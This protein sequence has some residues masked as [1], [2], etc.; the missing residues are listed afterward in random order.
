MKKNIRRIS[1]KNKPKDIYQLAYE[2][3]GEATPL[4][5]A[6]CGELCHGICCQGDEDTGM[7]LYPFEEQCYPKKNH[8]YRIIESEFVYDQHCV[9]ILTCPGQCLR[10][11]RPLAC[12]IFPLAPYQ[13]NR[14]EPLKIRI[15]PRSFSMCPLADQTLR[16]QID[17][18]FYQRVSR[19]LHYLNCYEPIHQFIVEM[20]YQMDE[21]ERFY[22]KAHL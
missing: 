12:R 4:Y 11:E 22:S 7:Y 14:E 1:F 20:S 13:K 6:D 5:H 17:P 9:K 2:E 16:S 18:M 15:D 21:Y 10:S 19:A 3:I 8:W